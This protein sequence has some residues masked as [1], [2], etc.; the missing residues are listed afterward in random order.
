MTRSAAVIASAVAVSAALVLV[1]A[2]LGG[3]RYTPTPA[4]DPCAPREWRSPHGLQAALE[5]IALSTADGA[6]CDLGVSREELVLALGSES[7][8][9]RFAAKHGLSHGDAE[10]AIRDGLVRAIDDGEQANAIG[11]DTARRSAR[12]RDPAA[13]RARPRRPSRGIGPAALLTSATSPARQRPRPTGFPEHRVDL[14]PR[15]AHGSAERPRRSTP[16]LIST[17][18]ATRRPNPTNI[19]TPYGAPSRSRTFG[20]PANPGW[21]NQAL[22]ASTAIPP[23]IAKNPPTIRPTSRTIRAGLSTI[24]SDASPAISGFAGEC[25]PVPRGATPAPRTEI[26]QRGWPFRPRAKRPLACRKL[27]GKRRPAAPREPRASR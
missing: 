2:A 18:P 7:D 5:Q 10:S 17:N 14:R 6:A 23:T 9:D 25:R 16:F 4:A 13:D 20:S 12:D 21:C 8:L 22:N 1:Y 15:S 3:G 24:V 27:K 19:K 11:S 26:A